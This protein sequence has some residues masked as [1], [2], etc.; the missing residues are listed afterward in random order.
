MQ[1]NHN[2]VRDILLFIETNTDYEKSHISLDELLSELP[3]NETTLSYHISKM[4][5]RDFFE[6]VCYSDDEIELISRLSHHGRAYLKK[7]S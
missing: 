3:Y 6:E 4:D 5:S 1:L 7:N 2:C